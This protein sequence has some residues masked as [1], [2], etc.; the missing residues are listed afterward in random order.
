MSESMSQS[1]DFER[2]ERPDVSEVSLGTIVS[3][4]ASDLSDLLR[5]ELELAKAE[6]RVEAQ[7]ASKG[8]GLLGGAGFAGWMLAVF[9]SLALMFA[10][11]AL[12]PLG[13]AALIVAVLWGIVG[14]VLFTRGRAQLKAVNPKPEQTVETLKEDVQ[15]AKTRTS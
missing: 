13:W 2:E 11:G 6:L 7:K 5:K 3:G 10:L 4:V 9:A 1:P 14:A 15:W 8:V 12:M